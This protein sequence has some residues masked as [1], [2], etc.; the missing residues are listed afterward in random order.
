MG[1][2]GEEP[3]GTA[4][5]RE[6]DRAGPL[7]LPQREAAEDHGNC[8]IQPSA[9]QFPLSPVH[10]GPYTNSP[11]SKFVHFL[12]LPLFWREIWGSQPVLFLAP[13]SL[14]FHS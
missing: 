7:T 5:G 8:P 10:C 12:F 6:E 4:W 14:P 1:F 11:D 13:A 9:V 3:R 2:R